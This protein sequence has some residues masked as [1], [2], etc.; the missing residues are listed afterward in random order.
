MNPKI[1]RNVS[2]LSPNYFAAERSKDEQTE[3]AKVVATELRSALPG[4][5]IRYKM[6]PVRDQQTKIVAAALSDAEREEVR[7]AVENAETLASN[8]R[9]PTPQA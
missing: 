3:I 6:D 7:A 4:Y 5:A 2:I 9:V 8:A 1:K